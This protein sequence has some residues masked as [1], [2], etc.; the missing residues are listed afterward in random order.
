MV[1]IIAKEM[2][3]DQVKKQ[4]PTML[5]KK[6]TQVINYYSQIKSNLFV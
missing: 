2:Q 5:K 3:K 6:Y 4:Y 1:G